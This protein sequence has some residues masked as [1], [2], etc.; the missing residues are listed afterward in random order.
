MGC[1]NKDEMKWMH[2]G[3]SAMISWFVTVE[4]TKQV[5]SLEYL[6]GE[7]HKNG[8]FASVYYLSRLHH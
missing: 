5:R 8:L 1:H 3:E 4:K 2:L 6:A 7:A